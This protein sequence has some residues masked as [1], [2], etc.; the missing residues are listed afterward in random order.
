MSKEA[1]EYLEDN[2]IDFGSDHLNREAATVLEAY[3]Q[4]RMQ[5]KLFMSMP[6]ATHS[7]LNDVTSPPPKESGTGVTS[8]T[9]RTIEHK[10]LIEGVS[11]DVLSRFASKLCYDLGLDFDNEEEYI[12]E[13]LKS[14]SNDH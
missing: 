8:F 1:E 3:H 11:K 4:E 2:G 7:P 9:S 12:E 14:L 10:A 13:Y 6:P 5:Q